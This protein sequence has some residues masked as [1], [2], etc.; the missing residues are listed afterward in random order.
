MIIYGFIMSNTIMC[1]R[2]I[3][4]VYF[5]KKLNILKSLIFLHI[6]LINTKTPTE[7]NND[8]TLQYPLNVVT[9]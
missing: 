3:G 1:N 4:N 5:D 2:Y 9:I 6:C 7:Y 8:G